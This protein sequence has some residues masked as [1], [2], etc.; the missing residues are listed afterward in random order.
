M[1]LNFGDLKQSRIYNFQLCIRHISEDSLYNKNYKLNQDS[2]TNISFLT[3][4]YIVENYGKTINK[5]ELNKWLNLKFLNSIYWK[6]L[7]FIVSNNK[8]YENHDNFNSDL[9]NYSTKENTNTNSDYYL[10]NQYSKSVKYWNIKKFE[11]NSF[12]MIVYYLYFIVCITSFLKHM[13]IANV[14]QDIIISFLNISGELIN[15]GLLIVLTIM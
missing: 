14:T 15:I 7:N 13:Y 8:N 12:L 3:D 1:I 2:N 4:S 6:H 9:L 5:K 11:S 10:S